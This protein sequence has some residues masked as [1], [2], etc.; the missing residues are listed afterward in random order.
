[1]P[2]YARTLAAALCLAAF[3]MEAVPAQTPV[4]GCSTVKSRYSCDKEQFRKILGDARSVAVETQPFNRISAKAG[5]DLA[6]EL[7]KSVQPGSAD[8]TF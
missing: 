8:L 2:I 1:M 7:G 6:R 5:E 4:A 3:N